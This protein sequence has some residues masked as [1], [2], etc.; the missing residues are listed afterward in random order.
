VG[1]AVDRVRRLG[2]DLTD[3]IAWAWSRRTLCLALGA[4]QYRCLEI[5]GAP[6]GIAS[7]RI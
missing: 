6:D 4:D 2:R 5:F 7:T 3:R 1:A